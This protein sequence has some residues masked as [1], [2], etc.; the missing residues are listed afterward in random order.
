MWDF[1]NSKLDQLKLDCFENEKGRVKTE[2]G[3]HRTEACVL[4]WELTK[5]ASVNSCGHTLKGAYGVAVPILLMQHHDY[6]L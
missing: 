5:V 2:L 4:R 3:F 6:D 1:C